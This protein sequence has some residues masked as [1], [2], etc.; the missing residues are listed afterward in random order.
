MQDASER[1]C[2]Q[3]NSMQTTTKNKSTSNCNKKVEKKIFEKDYVVN[4]DLDFS[5]L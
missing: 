2:N 5:S 1:V 4:N 3:I